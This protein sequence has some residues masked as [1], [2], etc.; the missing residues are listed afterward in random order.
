MATGD[1]GAEASACAHHT[2]LRLAREAGGALWAVA[3]VL[4]E[5]G[6]AA[7]ARGDA[8][9]RGE[10]TKARVDAK[11]VKAIV[12]LD[13]I[14]VAVAGSVG[15]ARRGALD[16]AHHH[17]ARKRVGRGVARAGVAAVEVLEAADGDIGR[18]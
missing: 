2:L 17:G 4:A 3:R 12:N 11:A 18:R 8:H 9:V 14:I 1:A 16:K 15:G 13:H 10:N 7:A 6:R 5:A